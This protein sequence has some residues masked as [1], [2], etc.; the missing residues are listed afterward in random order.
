MR[1]LLVAPDDCVILGYDGSN[2]EQFVAA[3][4]AFP[5]DNGAYADQLQG[6]AHTTNAIAYTKAAGREVKRGEGKNITYA[7]LY[8]AQKSKIA[9]MLGISLDA[10]QKVID[11]FWDTNYGLKALKENLERYWESTGK[12]YIRGI[13]G[14]KIYTRSKHSLVNAL[15]QSCGSIIMFL[16]G[17]Y[18]YDMLKEEGLIDKGVT[19]LA[20]VHDEYQ[21][22]VPKKLVKA[23]KFKTEEEAN[24]F[25]D[26]DGK[27]WSNVKEIDGVYYRF[28]SRVGEL[29]NISLQKAGEH[30]KMPLPFSA[31][32]DIGKNFAETH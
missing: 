23:R 30:F 1:S 17:C 5:Y 20:F 29:G 8:G 2:L 7:V 14:R 16:S 28:Y 24:N 27:L 4:Y 32:Y 6:D 15:F 13:D 10:A 21:Y 3:C 11:A 26:T 22:E 9:K 19:R 31:A 12:K 25:V 18:M